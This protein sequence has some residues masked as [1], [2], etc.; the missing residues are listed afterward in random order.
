MEH[1][2]PFWNDSWICVHVTALNLNFAVIESFVRWHL[3]MDSYWNYRLDIWIRV[4]RGLSIRQ[5]I[6]VFGIWCKMRKRG[7]P[8]VSNGKML[9]SSKSKVWNWNS[10]VNDECHTAVTA[11]ECRIMRIGVI[12][13]E[14]NGFQNSDLCMRVGAIGEFAYFHFGAQNMTQ[15]HTLSTV[16]TICLLV[17]CR[18]YKCNLM[19]KTTMFAVWQVPSK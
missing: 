2:L 10:M 15:F 19:P 18:P 8:C 5:R 13:S 3:E 12:S 7:R 11:N 4:A 6:G 14:W 16:Q 17:L 1:H 9:P